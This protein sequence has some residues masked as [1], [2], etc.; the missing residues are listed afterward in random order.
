MNKTELITQLKKENDKRAEKMYKGVSDY[1]HT[2]LVHEYNLTLEF[3][4]RLEAL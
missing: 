2:V 1:Q 4:K 3:I